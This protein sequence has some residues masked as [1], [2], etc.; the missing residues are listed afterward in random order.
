MMPTMAVNEI[1][2]ICDQSAC[3]RALLEPMS[4]RLTPDLSNT[5]INGTKMLV[6]HISKFARLSYKDCLCKWQLQQK[7]I[8]RLEGTPLREQ[9]SKK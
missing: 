3:S 2:P 1:Q 6:Q 4:N 5:N 7:G 9:H 8:A